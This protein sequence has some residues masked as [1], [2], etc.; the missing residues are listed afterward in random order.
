LQAE[1]SKIGGGGIILGDYENN[2]IKHRRAEC[3][4]IS[5]LLD[6]ILEAA[7]M[8]EDGEDGGSSSSSFT[9]EAD[10]C[11]R[12]ATTDEDDQQRFT[13]K[14]LLALMQREHASDHRRGRD[15]MFWRR[16]DGLLAKN[17]A[18]G[19]GVGA[20]GGDDNDGSSPIGNYVQ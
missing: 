4:R 2:S 16:V 12:T 19:N 20:K 18:R 17:R 6:R 8:L 1:A 9:V 3:E 10:H 11:G 5:G 15:A 7:T 13:A 14:P